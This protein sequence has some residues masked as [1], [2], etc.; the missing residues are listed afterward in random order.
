MW[1]LTQPQA[2]SNKISPQTSLQ[3]TTFRFGQIGDQS[4][5]NLKQKIVSWIRNKD[6][7]VGSPIRTP[8]KIARIGF[9]FSKASKP[10]LKSKLMVSI[11]N[12]Y[13]LKKKTINCSTFKGLQVSKLENYK[14]RIISLQH[15]I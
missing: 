1:I 13:L 4:I 15:I 7:A 11:C 12:P 6:T 8:R 5:C 10:D 14:H 9:S 2:H 3:K